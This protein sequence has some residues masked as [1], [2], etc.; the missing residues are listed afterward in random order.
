MARIA[1]PRYRDYGGVDYQIHNDND[2]I[3][4]FYELKG[5]EYIYKGNKSSKI[6][7]HGG[8][9]S[10]KAINNLKA[11]IEAFVNSSDTK[12]KETEEG[13]IYYKDPAEQ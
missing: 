10:K 1:N 5:A 8:T 6:G 7:A 12:K 3:S 4:P 9:V 11:A 2:P 13:T